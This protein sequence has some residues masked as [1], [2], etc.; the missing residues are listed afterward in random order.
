MFNLIWLKLS[1]EEILEQ[2]I[3]R[4]TTRLGLFF[5]KGD[6]PDLPTE[7]D[8]VYKIIDKFCLDYCELI[9]MDTEK[10]NFFEL[11]L[12]NITK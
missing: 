7:I 11:L 9:S 8:Q 5:D 10:A 1:E 6:N 2:S 4:L 12:K 3:E